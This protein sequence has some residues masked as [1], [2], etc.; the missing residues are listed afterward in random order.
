M[1]TSEEEN[2]ELNYEQSSI[3]SEPPLVI[4]TTL[5]NNEISRKIG[6]PLQDDG[7]TL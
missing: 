7:K 6:N 5:L 2:N 4:K 3:I 1:I